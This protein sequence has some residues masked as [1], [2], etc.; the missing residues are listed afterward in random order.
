MGS[1]ARRSRRLLF[2]RQVERIV[3]LVKL[4]VK[5]ELGTARRL[6]PVAEYLLDTCSA[7]FLVRLPEFL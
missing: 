1:H 4:I 3:P 5:S 7:H 6:D 2:E